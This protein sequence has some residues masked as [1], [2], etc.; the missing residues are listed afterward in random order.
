MD[1]MI[2]EFSA[3]NRHELNCIDS[4]FTVKSKLVLHTEGDTIGY[5]VVNVP[6]YV[7]HYPRHETTLEAYLTQQHKGIFFA[8]YKGQIVGQLILYQN[9]HDYAYI[10]DLVVDAEVRGRGIGR[11]LVDYAIQWAKERNCPGLMLE[12]QNINVAACHFYERC[13]FILG[14]FD[15][16]LYR[17]LTPDTEEIALYWYMLF[18]P[19]HA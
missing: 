1:I 19:S 5:S 2:E 18:S 15:Q 7:K 6:C 10:D 11:K 8:R 3:Q 13:G 4:V 12:T 14:G 9:W 16:Y 17:A